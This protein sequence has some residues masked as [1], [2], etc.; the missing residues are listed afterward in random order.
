MNNSEKTTTSPEEEAGVATTM[1]D[2]LAA[3]RLDI[4]AEQ[5]HIRQEER[6]FRHE[7]IWTSC[8]GVQ[9]DKR[10]VQFFSKLFIS[11]SVITFCFAQLTNDQLPAG[12]HSTYMS[13]LTLIVGVWLPS[14]SIEADAASSKHKQRSRQG[15]VG[16]ID[17][18]SAGQLRRPPRPPR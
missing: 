6:E 9:F 5:M 18:T 12:M 15:V 4:M 13:L 7:N 10:S 11:T 1:D 16:D 17:N 3:R 14:P 2:A 8:C